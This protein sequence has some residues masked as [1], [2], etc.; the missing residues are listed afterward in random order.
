MTNTAQQ[1]AARYA[2][3]NRRFWLGFF[4]SVILWLIAAYAFSDSCLEMGGGQPH[5]SGH[6]PNFLTLF[7][8]LYISP[9]VP[10]AICLW[11]CALYTGAKRRKFERAMKSCMRQA[12]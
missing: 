11:I 8:V 9:G 12:E 7:S 5:C 2:K 10:L 4:C 3:L 6:I 1:A